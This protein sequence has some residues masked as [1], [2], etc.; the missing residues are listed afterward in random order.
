MN[1]IL[2]RMTKT[3]CP[4]LQP[5]DIL[6]GYLNGYLTCSSNDYDNHVIETRGT[7]WLILRDSRGRNAFMDLSDIGG[8]AGTKWY[9]EMIERWKT[10]RS[11]YE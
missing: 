7:D 2:I 11:T 9:D 3:L 4:E 10:P 1:E 5:G 6:Y 8:S